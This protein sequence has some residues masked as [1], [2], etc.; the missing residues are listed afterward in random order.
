MIWGGSWGWENSID[1]VL[2]ALVV[3]RHIDTYYNKMHYYD[4]LTH[5]YIIIMY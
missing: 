5:N 1:F 2:G 3:T 4:K